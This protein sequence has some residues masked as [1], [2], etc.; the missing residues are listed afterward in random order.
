MDPAPTPADALFAER[1]VAAEPSWR[2]TAPN[3]FLDPYNCITC[4]ISPGFSWPT[5]AL[6]SGRRQI[7]H[8]PPP[9]RGRVGRATQGYR[10]AGFDGCPQSAPGPVG[11]R[12]HAARLPAVRARGLARVVSQAA[13]SPC[14]GP[15]GRRRRIVARGAPQTSLFRTPNG[16]CSNL[17]SANSPSSPWSQRSPL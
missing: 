7:R 16:A 1:I 4:S 3:T 15:N 9:A 13:T 11:T 10:A 14:R 17:S 8:V 6:F 12:S 2:T 5:P